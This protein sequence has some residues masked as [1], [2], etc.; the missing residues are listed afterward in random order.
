[1]RSLDR[2]PVVNVVHRGIKPDIR[3][4][5]DNGGYRGAIL[6][7][8]AGMD[9]IAFLSMPAGQ[10]FCPLSSI[11]AVRYAAPTKRAKP[12]KSKRT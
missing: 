11:L 8:H 3:L 4:L 12:R 1:V 5:L 9:T 6:L 10:V 2:D 7:T